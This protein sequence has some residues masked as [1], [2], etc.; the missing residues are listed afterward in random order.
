M[1]ISQPRMNC[2]QHMLLTQTN[3]ATVVPDSI[4]QIPRVRHDEMTLE[5]EADIP[6]QRYCGMKKTDMP[7]TASLRSPLPLTVL[8]RQVSSVQRA[9]VMDLISLNNT[10]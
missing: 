2:V 6:I 1:L 8:A 9:H 3:N 7:L 10:T 5:N 4:H